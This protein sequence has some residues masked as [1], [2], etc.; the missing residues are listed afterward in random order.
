MIEVK[1]KPNTKQILLT[2]FLLITIFSFS[3]KVYSQT[4]YFV[5][6]SNFKFYSN[7]LRFQFGK[8][9]TFYDLSINVTTGILNSTVNT[10]TIT[11]ELGSWYLNSINNCTIKVSWTGYLNSVLVD[12]TNVNATN[13]TFNFIQNTNHVI[14]WHPISYLS[15]W[16]NAY[17]GIAGM[18]ILA[19]SPLISYYIGYKKQSELRLFRF[20]F[21]ELGLGILG[22]GLVLGFIYG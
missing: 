12:S 10:I 18:V 17:F 5:Q 13:N 7:G 15:K 8:D 4:Y 19:G 21:I 9:A 1:W 14:D 11:E 22:L 3:Y 2:V 16:I 6:T 20:M